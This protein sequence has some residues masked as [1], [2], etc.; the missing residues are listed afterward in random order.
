MYIY[1]KTERGNDIVL[2]L[3]V[4]ELSSPREINI[5]NI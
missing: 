3:D 4:A 5:N 1:I 2:K